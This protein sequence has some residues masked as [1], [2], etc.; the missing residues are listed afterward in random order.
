MVVTHCFIH[1]THVSGNPCHR[2]TFQRNC[3]SK[4]SYALEKS[5]FHINPVVPFLCHAATISSAS[6][7][8]SAI[9]RPSRKADWKGLIKG[10]KTVRSRL[11][12][13]LAMIRYKEFDSEIGRKSRT[14]SAPGTLGMSTIYTLLRRSRLQRPTRKSSNVAITSGPTV[15]QQSL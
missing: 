13:T 4:V 12:K 9:C 3:Q 10:G 5:T 1:L 7:I 14:C 11:A 6:T 8:L 2:K 15:S